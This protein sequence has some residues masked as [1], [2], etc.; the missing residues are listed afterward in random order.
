MK[1][2][3]Q[4]LL[5]LSSII[6]GNDLE[7]I[8]KYLNSISAN[9]THVKLDIGLSYNAPQSQV[10]L[11]KEGNLLVFGFEPNPESVE[12]ISAG[13]IKKRAEDHGKPL[14]KKYIDEARFVLLPIALSN[15]DSEQQMD[16]YLSEKDCGTSSLYQPSQSVLGPIKKVVKVSVFSLKHFFDLFPWDKFAYI[17]YIKIDAQGSDLKILKSAGQYL[18]EK[19]VYVT[20]E[21][22]GYQY[23]NASDCSL[24]NIKEYMLGQGFDLVDHPN[25]SDPTFLN[26]RYSHLKDAVFIWQS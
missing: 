8:S 4:A 7:K 14:D 16:F 1:I 15:V 21:A 3:I 13:N 9:V 2:K 11:E 26:R 24:K 23:Q 10:W 17:D 18:S 25:T 20:A 19:V 6:F 5:V 12:T 22:D